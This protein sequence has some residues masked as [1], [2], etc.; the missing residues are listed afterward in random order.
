M[1]NL[2]T[3]L[4]TIFRAKNQTGCNSNIL[5]RASNVHQGN[6]MHS[7]NQLA[8][9]ADSITIVC[10][11]TTAI[12]GKPHIQKIQSDTLGRRQFILFS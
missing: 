4:R 9:L 1:L 11:I 10:A 5:T 12:D 8:N 3:F 2:N 6:P 7:D